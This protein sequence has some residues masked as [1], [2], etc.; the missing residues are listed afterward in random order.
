MEAAQRVSRFAAEG[1]PV[2]YRASEVL[3]HEGSSGDHC[4]AIV[5]GEVLVTTSST[6]GSTIVL[7]RRGPGDIVGQLSLLDGAPRSARVVATTNVVARRLNAA[8]LEQ[9]L[10][11]HPDM[12]MAEIRRLAAEVRSLSRRITGRS[13]ELRIRVL[14]LLHTHADATGEAVFRSTREELAGWVGATREAVTRT[15]SDLAS[16]GVVALARCEVRLLS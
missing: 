4:V 1:R 9:L 10:L 14:D 13:E 8:E 12:A 3:L 5:E 15:L 7:G 2:D 11:A 6:T 16:E